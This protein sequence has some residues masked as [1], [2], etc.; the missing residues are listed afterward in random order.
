MSP[1]AQPPD[2]G[3]SGDGRRCRP[4]GCTTDRWRRSRAGLRAAVQTLTARMMSERAVGPAR[5]R[6]PP[7]R[8]ARRPRS[9]VDDGSGGVGSRPSP[10]QWGFFGGLGVLIA[11]VSFLVLDTIRDTLVLIAIA[12]LLAIGLDPLVVLMTR[13]GC[14]AGPGLLSSSSGLLLVIAAA[15]LR[16]HPADRQ[17]GRFVRRHRCRS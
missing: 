10:F 17:R 3:G 8:P 2:G 9:A 12:T 16:D 4:T 11:Y 14:G 5:R 13:R 6:P 1:V 15:D 7:R